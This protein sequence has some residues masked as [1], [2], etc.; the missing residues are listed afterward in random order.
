MET[1][2][3]ITP[4]NID[5]NFTEL[6]NFKEVHVFKKDYGYVIG[7]QKG[8]DFSTIN[9]IELKHA[10]V[11]AFT[12]LANE[13]EIIKEY[14]TF[15]TYEECIEIIQNRDGKTFESFFNK[16]KITGHKFLLSLK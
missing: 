1:K 5:Y 6:N 10:I 14:K 4:K 8:C 16:G 13:K 9:Y 11:G 3:T 12:F 15:D 2:K 7:Y